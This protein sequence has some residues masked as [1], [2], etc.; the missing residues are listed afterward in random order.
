MTNA[1]AAAA[2]INVILLSMK[3]SS[4]CACGHFAL[5]VVADNVSAGP[6]HGPAWF[7]NI[8]NGMTARIA[9]VRPRSRLSNC[10]FL[11]PGG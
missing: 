8:V 10:G 9:G 7:V 1:A 4:L 3:S 2:D 5:L 11:P 6:D